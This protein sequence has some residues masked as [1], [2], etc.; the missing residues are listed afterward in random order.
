MLLYTALIKGADGGA[1]DS[2]IGPFSLSSFGVM[3][4]VWRWPDFES[5]DMA[6]SSLVVVEEYAG[7]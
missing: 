7:R 1:R 2:C 3:A 4:G 5:E 6:G